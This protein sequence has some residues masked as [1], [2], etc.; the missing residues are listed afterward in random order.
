MCTMIAEHAEISGSGMGSSGWFALGKVNV[1]YDHPNHAHAEYAINI[2]FFDKS[3]ELTE[4]VAVEL[5]P[6]SARDLVAAI[7]MVLEK[8]LPYA[9]AHTN[10]APLHN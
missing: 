2:D 7:E 1:S 4:R 5:T 6:N 9:T 3:S 8:G 10:T